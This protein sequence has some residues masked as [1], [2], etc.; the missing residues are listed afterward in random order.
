MFRRSGLTTSLAAICFGNVYPL[1]F[2]DLLISYRRS[3]ISAHVL[4]PGAERRQP[5]WVESLCSYHNNAIASVIETLVLGGV[6]TLGADPRH[7]L[8]SD[9]QT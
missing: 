9:R 3:D 1:C 7:G 2:L 8:G 6:L 4:I 5:V